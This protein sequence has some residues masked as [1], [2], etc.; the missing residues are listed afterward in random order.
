M[1]MTKNETSLVSNA[2]AV[3]F[4]HA[5]IEDYTIGLFN[6]VQKDKDNTDQEKARM[7]LADQLTKE[8]CFTCARLD[9]KTL[10]CSRCK[11]VCH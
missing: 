11:V 1:C 8:C 2:T 9:K 7:V 10:F 4:I 6:F 3:C 5:E